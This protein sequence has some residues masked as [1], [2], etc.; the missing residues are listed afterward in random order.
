[1]NLNKKAM[2]STGKTIT[3]LALVGALVGLAALS[4]CWPYV[5]LRRKRLDALAKDYSALPRVPE[6]PHDTQVII[7]LTTLPSRM[8]LLQHTLKSLLHQTCRADLILLNLP[9]YS[10]KENC[11]YVVPP[12]IQFL[13]AFP[14]FQINWVDTDY[15]PATKLLPTLTHSAV[16]PQDRIVVVDDDVLYGPK[17]V[18]RLCTYAAHHPSEAVTMTGWHAKH[19]KHTPAG[20][21]TL[22]AQ[23]VDALQGYGGYLVRPCFFD[24]PA[25]LDFSVA[26]RECRIADD[27]WISGHLHA[28]QH[29]IT[30]LPFNCKTIPWPS[31]AYRINAIH[32]TDNKN[33]NANNVALAWM[34]QQF[35]VFL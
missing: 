25:V 35:N 26:P 34:H 21:V 18:E 15:G 1:M 23:P 32:L 4:V 10:A 24:V 14:W 7:S 2:R 12:D 8:P 5:R 17:L 29:T 22:W 19:L 11:P 31:G 20:L 16:K 3:S 28:R 6:K 33:G 30:R 13:T 9:R 27:V